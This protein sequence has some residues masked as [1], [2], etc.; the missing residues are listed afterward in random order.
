MTNLQPQ[1]HQNMVALWQQQMDALKEIVKPNTRGGSSD[2]RHKVHWAVSGGQGRRA[3][4][5]RV[6]G[7]AVLVPQSVHPARHGVDIVGRI[8]AWHDRQGAHQGGPLGDDR[9]YA[10]LLNC[11]EEDHFNICYSVADG[12]GPEAMSFLMILP[13]KGEIWRFYA[14]RSET[15]AFHL[16]VRRVVENWSFSERR[17]QS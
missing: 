10:I 5:W 12:N 1:A 16:H 6:E 13:N 4:V 2:D 14:P 9:L 8:R 17:L 3:A 7:Q 15:T 11:T